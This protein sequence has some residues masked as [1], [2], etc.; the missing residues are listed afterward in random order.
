MRLPSLEGRLE[1]WA[2][3]LS[4]GTTR[5]APPPYLAVNAGRSAEPNNFSSV[6]TSW[7]RFARLTDSAP[8]ERAEMAGRADL[9]RAEQKAV[10]TFAHEPEVAD[11]VRNNPTIPTEFQEMARLMSATKPPLWRRI[12]R[13]T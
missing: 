13:R 5:A 8:A 12:L 11:A 2:A 3:G 7:S 9:S 6:W 10:I 4:K 1:L